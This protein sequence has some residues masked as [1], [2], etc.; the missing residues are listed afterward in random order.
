M[1]GASCLNC[2]LKQAYSGS[3][4]NP[5]LCR[6]GIYVQPTHPAYNRLLDF[7]AFLSSLKVPISAFH[8]HYPAVNISL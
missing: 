7:A 1:G 8:N 6:L 5:L 2:H 3:I 4:N